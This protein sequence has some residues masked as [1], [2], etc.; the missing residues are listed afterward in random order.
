MSDENEDENFDFNFEELS[1]EEKAELEKERQEEDRKLRTHPLYIQAGEIME[2][3]DVLLDSAEQE[4]VKEM[5]GSTLRESA[6]I[7]IAKLSSGLTSD[8][9][10]ISM[11]KAA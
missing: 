3:I 1:E 4:D 7:I 6:M 5:Y 9:Y 2:I 8:S 11:Q 10:I